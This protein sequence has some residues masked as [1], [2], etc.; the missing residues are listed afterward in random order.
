MNESS[1]LWGGRFSGE[2]NEAVAAL[3]RSIH[4]DWRLAKYD[5]AGTRAHI[6]A[7]TAAGY[8]TEAEQVKLDKSLVELDNACGIW[9]VHC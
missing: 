8:L 4:F 5:I 2:T 1:S 9:N 3:S 6:L 7:L